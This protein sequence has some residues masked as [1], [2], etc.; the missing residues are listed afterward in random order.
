MQ[1]KAVYTLHDKQSSTMDLLVLVL[2]SAHKANV[3]N[4]TKQRIFK[5][6]KKYLRK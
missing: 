3:H 4:L 6:L 1:I 5:K 2:L